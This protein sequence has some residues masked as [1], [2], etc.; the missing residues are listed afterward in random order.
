MPDTINLQEAEQQLTAAT[1]AVDQLK[2]A[3][4]DQGPGSVTAEELGQAALT[5]EHCKLALAHA[6]KT[7]DEQ[8]EQQR[9]DMLQQLKADTLPKVGSSETARAAVQ[10]IADG[11]ATLLSES[12]TRQHT[13]AKLIAALRF[14]GVPRVSAGQADK[15][16]GLAWTEAA[17]GR[18]DTVYIDGRQITTINAGLP[19]GAGII[20]GCQAAGF[21]SRHL[22][23]VVQVDGAQPI[24]DNLD[25]WLQSRY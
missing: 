5:V 22:A 20:L 15:H 13:V 16:A 17:M 3:I 7:A 18:A 19:I 24:A 1:A 10:Q 21:S 9:I 14:A 11:V 4:L 12:G 2:Q 25:T 8:A 23:P 6:A